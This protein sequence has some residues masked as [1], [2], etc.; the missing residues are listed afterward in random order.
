MCGRWAPGGP[1]AH[2][3][4][5]P[6]P[7]INLSVSTAGSASPDLVWQRYLRTELWSSW[8][9]QIRRVDPDGARLTL[10]LT[11]VVHGPAGIGARFVVTG[12]DPASRSWSWQVRPVLG[13]RL[14]VPFTLDLDHTVDASAGQGT[15][16]TAGWPVSAPVRAQRH[17]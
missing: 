11:G 1:G 9:P 16:T 10:G 6:A 12:L 4:D 3:G 15:R 14:G 17:R 2:T 7:R 5:V 13:T 8:S